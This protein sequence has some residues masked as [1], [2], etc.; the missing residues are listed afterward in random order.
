MKQLLSVTFHLHMAEAGLKPTTPYSSYYVHSYEPGI[1]EI[2]IKL[3]V[4]NI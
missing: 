2:N 3:D 1:K 4:Q